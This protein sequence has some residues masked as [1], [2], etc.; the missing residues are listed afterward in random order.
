MHIIYFSSFSLLLQKKSLANV[1]ATSSGNI[2]VASA[3]IFTAVASFLFCPR[4]LL[5]LA[6]HLNHYHRILGQCL[7][8]L[9]IQ[10]HFSNKNV[11]I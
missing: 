6:W 8:K 2:N 10:L 9:Q 1:F 11:N 3:N 5:R 7:N 4:I